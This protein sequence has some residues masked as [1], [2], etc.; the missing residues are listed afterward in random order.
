MR[1]NLKQQAT[2]RTDTGLYS[3]THGFNRYIMI[4]YLVKT[5]K[6]IKPKKEEKGNRRF[7][8]SSTT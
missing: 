6:K 2:V 3:T 8:C 5:D 7:T 1:I 4:A